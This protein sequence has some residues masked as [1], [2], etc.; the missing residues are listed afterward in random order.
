MNNINAK[1]LT[2]V[3]PRSPYE[4]IGGFAIIARTIDKCRA[5]IAE[6]NGDYHFN[7]PLDNLLF[8]FK[9]IKGDDFKAYVAEGHSDEEIAEWVKNNGTPKTEEEISAW[10]NSFKTDFSYSTNPEKKDWFFGECK[11]L[12][13]DPMKTTL[14]DYLEVDDKVSYAKG[15]TCPI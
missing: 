13:L 5:T 2:K 12:G 6:T 9:G 10:S 8:S 1:D 3:A 15:E 14:F 11:R 4:Q 7:C